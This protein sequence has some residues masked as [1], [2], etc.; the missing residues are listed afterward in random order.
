MKSI[1]LFF[2]FFST[3]A[4]AGFQPTQ[5]SINAI[6]KKNYE[7]IR[8][9]P[10]QLA[11]F[12]KTKSARQY[13]AHLKKYKI[14]NLPNMDILA[15]GLYV[16]VAKLKVS[17]VE[18]NSKTGI[19][20]WKINGKDLKWDPKAD[21][22]THM[23]S[24]EAVL[25]T[26]VSWIEWVLPSAEAA[27]M[28]VTL[29][30]TYLENII[31][32]SWF[33]MGSTPNYAKIESAEESVC[34]TAEAESQLS[35]RTASQL[36]EEIQFLAHIQVQYNEELKSCS[37]SIDSAEC[38]ADERANELTGMKDC[39]FRRSK[40]ARDSLSADARCASYLK[41][42]ECLNKMVS[43]RV[44]L[45]QKDPS[46]SD[47]PR[48]CFIAKGNQVELINPYMESIGGSEA[49]DL[50]NQLRRSRN[51]LVP[52]LKAAGQYCY[53]TSSTEYSPSTGSK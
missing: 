13:M 36:V 24:Y 53:P 15:S 45:I 37:K 52:L 27:D 9:N 47:I 38:T 18:M 46:Y 19:M 43:A 10:A 41:M 42:Q 4:T 20:T 1:V 17:F 12:M 50:S 32:Y 49:F 31:T 11:R 21:F 16:P 34:Q 51:N 33:G 8:K 39:F 48:E 6:L 44:P 28:P 3:F 5:E 25:K 29:S 23:K 30:G 40:E 35:T 7:H 22:K 14:Q 26:K 2:A